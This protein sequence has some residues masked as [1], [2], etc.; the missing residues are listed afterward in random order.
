MASA[1]ELT[2]IVAAIFVG[3]L[4]LTLVVLLG[5]ARRLSRP[6][7]GLV[8]F[9]G[10]IAAG[11]LM[12]RAD[13]GGATEIRA[14]AQAMNA[15]VGEMTQSRFQRA[16]QQ[17]MSRELDLARTVQQALV[18]DERVIVRPFVRVAGHFAPSSECGG[19]WWT[20]EDLPDGSVL[21]VIGDAT[22]H[23]PA[24]A[25]IAAAAK[26]ACDVA[27]ATSGR[28]LEVARLLQLMSFAVAQSGRRRMSMSCFAAIFD[29]RRQTITFANAGHNFPFLLRR[30][31]TAGLKPLVARGNRL[32]EIGHELPVEV[33]ERWQP[34]DVLFLYTDGL[35]ECEN[36]AGEAF[37]DK[38]LRRL[39]AT[40]D[41]DAERMRARLLEEVGRFLGGADPSDD[42]TFALAEIDAG[43]GGV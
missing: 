31:G 25:I 8:R 41:G 9:T 3:A 22:G 11:D 38:R 10:Q 19:D 15:M 21:L 27:R 28:A 16:V 6:L 34:G 4:T 43:A 13:T 12:V 24:A 36:P 40:L 29:P 39:L 30:A 26:A 32:G 18:P 7:K 2:R 23:G 5:L 33:V 42:L 1:R 17:R 20:V 14:L 35:V 37:G